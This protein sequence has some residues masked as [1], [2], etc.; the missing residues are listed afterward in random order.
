MLDWK[1]QTTRH[2]G[3]MF[4]KRVRA[5]TAGLSRVPTC[6]RDFTA[7]D[8]EDGDV[9]H[10]TGLVDT[11]SHADSFCHYGHGFSVVHTLL[12]SFDL[13]GSNPISGVVARANKNQQKLIC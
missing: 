2:S 9:A 6:R 4:I 1:V 5:H 8:I 11:P 7:N 3:K 10:H 12:F 13:D